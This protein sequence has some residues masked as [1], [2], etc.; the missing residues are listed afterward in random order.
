MVES[1]YRAIGFM[2]HAAVAAQSAKS[3][4][5]LLQRSCHCR[6]DGPTV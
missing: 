2:S 1:F 5:R 6:V 4:H 3:A